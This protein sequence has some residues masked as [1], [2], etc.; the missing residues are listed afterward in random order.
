MQALDTSA[1]YF[2]IEFRSDTARIFNSIFL[3]K[4]LFIAITYINLLVN[5]MLVTR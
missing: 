1:Y 2:V 5:E 4:K 3:R